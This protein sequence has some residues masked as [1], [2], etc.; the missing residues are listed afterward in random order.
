MSLVVFVGLIFGVSAQPANAANEPFVGE[1]M[2]FGGNFCPN[3]WAEANGQV[4]PISG[5]Q[6]LY[7]IYGTLYG[8]DGTK[9]FALPDLRGRSP[10]GIGQEIPILPNYVAGQKGGIGE[11]VQ[12]QSVTGKL[13][14]GYLVV[15]YCVAKQGIYPP[16]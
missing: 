8:G 5:N 12:P 2:L 3:G 16:R 14:P 11:L 13:A 4:L 7:S 9:N 15:R 1:I 10:V 6:D